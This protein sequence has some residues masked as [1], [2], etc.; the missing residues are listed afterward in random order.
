MKPDKILIFIAVSITI[1]TILVFLNYLTLEKLI[2]LQL[3]TKQAR[4]IGEL[5]I[6]NN[7]ERPANIIQSFDNVSGFATRPNSFCC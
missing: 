5:A 1:V 6:N 3:E 2:V 7:A 4:Q